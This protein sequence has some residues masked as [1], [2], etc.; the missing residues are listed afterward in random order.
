VYFRLVCCGGQSRSLLRAGK[1]V[2]TYSYV[3]GAAVGVQCPS[4]SAPPS[5]RGTFEKSCG[6]AIERDHEH[7]DEVSPSS[8][9]RCAG[10]IPRLQLSLAVRDSLHARTGLKGSKGAGSPGLAAV[11][12][13]RVTVLAAPAA[14]QRALWVAPTAVKTG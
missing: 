1:V 8:S 2:L 6:A 3:A 5:R 9:A 14:R 13:A 7:V 4:G 10:A 12:P 11:M